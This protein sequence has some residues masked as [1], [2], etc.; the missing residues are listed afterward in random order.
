MCRGLL[1]PEEV[2]EIHATETK[3]YNYITKLKYIIRL[4][5][6]EKEKVMA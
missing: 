5:T 4:P 2:N 1:A 6:D 3:F